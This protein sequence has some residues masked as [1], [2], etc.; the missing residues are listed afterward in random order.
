MRVSAGKEPCSGEVVENSHFPAGRRWLFLIIGGGVFLLL[1][2]GIVAYGYLGAVAERAGIARRG[3]QGINHLGHIRAM[4]EPLQEY[5]GLM[6]MGFT[7]RSSSWPA[8]LESRERERLTAVDEAFAKLLSCQIEEGDPLGLQDEINSIHQ[9]W[10]RLRGKHDY[11]GATQVFD[12]FTASIARLL[13]LHRLAIT[14]SGLDLDPVAGTYNLIQ[15]LDLMLEFALEPTGQIR[16]L[17]SGVL[18]APAMESQMRDR[19][20]ARANLLDTITARIEHH[21]LMAQQAR[22]DLDP[23]LGNLPASLRTFSAKIQELLRY[24]PANTEKDQGD[25]KEFFSAATGIISNGYLLYDAALTASRSGITQRFDQAKTTLRRSVPLFLLIGLGTM[26]LVGWGLIGWRR[27]L[28]DSEEICF[29]IRFQRMVADISSRFLHADSENIDEAINELLGA[30]GEFFVARRIALFRFSPGGRRMF[31][32]H[33]WASAGVGPL[34]ENLLDIDLSDLPW[35]RRQVEGTIL[36]GRL[37][38]ISNIEKLPGEAVAEQRVFR[39]QNILSFCSVPVSI[40][41]KAVGFIGID[42]PAPGG[43]NLERTDHLLTVI[44][45]LLSAALERDELERELT[46]NA[47]TDGLTAL[48]NRRHFFTRLTAQIEEYRRNRQPFALAI[49]DIDHFKRLNDTHGHLAGDCVLKQ[50][51]ALLK[52]GFRAFDIV[53]RYGGEEFVVMLLDSDGQKAAAIAQRILETTRAH[54]FICEDKTLR[55]TVSGGVVEV[56]EIFERRL[57]PETLVDEGDK[58]LYRAKEAGRDRIIRG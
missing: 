27:H 57:T 21:A 7:S 44:A 30:S 38:R 19:I 36:K 56:G 37:L 31:C 50:F 43:E 35:W 2:L 48:Y 47:L 39:E 42:L 54:P 26:A 3:L 29:Q 52:E 18:A 49:F 53:A 4:I 33:Q 46:T 5:R 13:A 9:E 23:S 34:N 40:R 10:Q 22:P 12:E 8:N 16:A 14:S 15:I 1:L 17:Y 11:S 24:Y 41:K 45:N 51:A 32:T 20:I 28:K 58:R 25:A 55:I 6:V